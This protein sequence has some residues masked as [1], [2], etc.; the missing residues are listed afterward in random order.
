[1]TNLANKFS[2]AFPVGFLAVATRATGAACI[3]WVNCNDFNSRQSRFVFDELAKLKERPSG[4]LYSLWLAKLVASVAYALEVFKSDVSRSVLS[5]HNELFADLVVKVSPETRL[6]FRNSF[7]FAAN[8]QRTLPAILL[9]IAFALK[10]LTLRVVAQSDRLNF[11]AAMLFAKA[12]S[13]QIDNSQINAKK[14]SRWNGRMFRQVNRHKQEPLA[15]F[16]ENQITLPFSKAES[17]L[18]I[19]AHHEGNNYALRQGLDRYAV[20]P[21]EAH[22]MIIKRHSRMLAKLWL[23]GFIP[24]EGFRDL[25][26]ATDSKLRRQGESFAQQGVVEFLQMKLI[27]SL[28]LK[29]FLSKPVCGFIKGFDGLPQFNGL[30]FI[31]KQL[32]LQGKFHS[33]SV[34]YKLNLSIALIHRLVSLTRELNGAK[35]LPIDKSRGF[36]SRAC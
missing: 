15:V 7:Q 11:F 19:F 17:L 24:F 13:R 31:W 23:D 4:N 12:I 30:L 3:A 9:L 33:P 26:N 10:A 29:G 35:F 34:A 18:L 6:A 28:S 22:Q 1:M 20:K 8:I 14:I 32:S 25:S 5:Q 21:F 27:G 36:L 2:L 16:S